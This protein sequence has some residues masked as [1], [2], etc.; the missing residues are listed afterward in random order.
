MDE[1]V[2][3]FYFAGHRARARARLDFSS[4]KTVT[5]ECT[6]YIYTVYL[7][8]YTWIAIPLSSLCDRVYSVIVSREFSDISEHSKINNK[9]K[10]V[11]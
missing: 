11:F 4:D 3:R 2:S 7:Y 6:S 9:K 5:F 1:D 10:M 8:I